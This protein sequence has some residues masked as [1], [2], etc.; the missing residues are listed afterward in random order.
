MN[1]DSAMRYMSTLNQLWDGLVAPIGRRTT[2]SFD[3]PGARLT[4]GLQVQEGTLRA[5]LDKV[6]SLPR[7]IGF[8]A[9]FLLS[10]PEST[11]GTRLFA[12]PPASWPE[13]SKFNRRITSILEHDLAIDEHGAL[14]PQM[15]Q[16]AADAK[17]RWVE[18]HDSV[19]RGLAAS[20][21]FASVSDAAAKSADNVARLAALFQVFGKGGDISD[22]SL[23]RAAIIVEWHLGEA[24]RFFGEMAMA[25]DQVNAIRLND[26]MVTY[27]QRK[28]VSVIPRREIQR[29]AIPASLREKAVLNEALAELVD[30]DRVQLVRNERRKDVHINPALLDGSCK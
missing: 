7:D 20:G 4:V 27:C 25:R 3:V 22:D 13:L 26:W 14:T 18:F 21:R 30:A 23:R 29:G 8:L 1:S 16:M 12:E 9:R 24:R 19:E 6:G 17:Q 28:G 5:F 11:Q 15:L 10:C 2:D